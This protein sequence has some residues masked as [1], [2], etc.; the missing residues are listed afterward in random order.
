MNLKIPS[1]SVDAGTQAN[2]RE[3]TPMF[4]ERG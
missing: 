1:D 4:A 2:L 3:E